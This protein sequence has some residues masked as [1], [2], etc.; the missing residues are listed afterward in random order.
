MHFCVWGGSSGRA[1]RV[2]EGGG[3]P[4]LSA[5]QR[6]NYFSSTGKIPYRDFL[7][8]NSKSPVLSFK[9]KVIPIWIL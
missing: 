2:E 5:G 9:L 4:G 7:K 8:S 6:A 1:P 3:P